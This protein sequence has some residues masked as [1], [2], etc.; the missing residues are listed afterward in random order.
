MDKKALEAQLVAMRHQVMS[1][2]ASIEAALSLLDDE[3]KCEHK[4]RINLTVMGGPEEW[5]CRDCGYHYKEG[6]S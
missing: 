6:E 3:E 4:N 1:M 2:A 5:Q